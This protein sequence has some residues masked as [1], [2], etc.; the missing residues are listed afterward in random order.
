MRR[1]AVWLVASVLM[2]PGCGGSEL[3]GTA[4]APVSTT[5]ANWAVYAPSGGGYRVELPVD[6]QAIDAGKLAEDGLPDEVRDKNPFLK[7]AEA[8]FAAVAGRIGTLMAFDGTD[9][10]KRII[11][12]TRFAPTIIVIR[13]EQVPDR[14]EAD[15][16]AEVASTVR[17]Q[18]LTLPSVA[19]VAVDELTIAGHPARSVTYSMEA[20][21]GAGPVTLTETDYLVVGNGRLYQVS[22]TT[23][24]SDTERLEPACRHAVSTLELTG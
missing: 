22:C 13:G 24:D 12:R 21:F 23:I 14:P 2:L 5:D 1:H 19:T 10:G 7:D 9:E 6:W 18:A 15:V 8:R 11:Q 16:V 20:N 3:A 17:A 4:P